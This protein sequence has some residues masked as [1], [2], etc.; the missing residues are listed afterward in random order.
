[1]H[2]RSFF[3]RG[4]HSNDRCGSEKERAGTDRRLVTKKAN[5]GDNE[6]DRD[7]YPRV[8]GKTDQQAGSV[9]EICGGDEWQSG[10]DP[11]RPILAVQRRAHEII[12][13]VAQSIVAR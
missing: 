12:R 9:D 4:S 5:Y 6:R 7:R 3:W 1:V 13:A 8:A 11:A 10:S 2:R